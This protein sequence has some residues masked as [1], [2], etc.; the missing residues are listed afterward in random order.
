MNHNEFLMELTLGKKVLSLKARDENHRKLFQQAEAR[1]NQKMDYYK[2]KYNINDESTF[3]LMIC[4]DFVTDLIQCENE[5]KLYQSHL[6]SLS[7]ELEQ[8]LVLNL[9]HHDLATDD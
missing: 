6:E 8:A 2:K 4:L 9:H 5:L 1:I 3:Y 7:L